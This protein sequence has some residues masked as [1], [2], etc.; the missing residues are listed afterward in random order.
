MII[1]FCTPGYRGLAH[2][3][4]ASAERHGHDVEIIDAPELGDWAANCAQKAGVVRDALIRHEQVLFLDADAEV[5]AP[6]DELL[7]P[8]EG[9]RLH[10]V[11]PEQ[12]KPGWF[13]Q[14]YRYQAVKYGGMWNSGILSVHRSPETLA[15]MD[16]W[17]EMCA[18]RPSEWDQLCLQWAHRESGSTVEVRDIPAQYRAGKAIIGHRSAFHTKWKRAEDVPLRRVVLLGSAEYVSE[19]WAANRS[20]YLDRGFAVAAVNNACAVAGDDLDLWLTP[21]DY[22][23]E[24]RADAAPNNVASYPRATNP[25]GNWIAHPHWISKPTT[26]M[27]SA[28][29]HLLNEAVLDGCRIE[30]HVAGCDMDY[31]ANQTHFY[32]NGTPDPLRFSDGQL[33]DAQA[34]LM[35]MYASHM[36]TIANAGGRETTRL[37]FPR[38][39]PG[40]R[41][42]HSTHSLGEFLGDM[43]PATRRRFER[44]IGLRA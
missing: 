43:T 17:V 21:N 31:G 1:T 32:G 4:R 5:R 20:R 18:R 38:V 6:I 29:L 22:A 16:A 39:E 27:L 11:T 30:V 37:I 35:G 23:G 24:F 12:F 25:E 7:K 8:H 9:I 13:A 40:E 36:S 28:A 26:V 19:W 10:V 41:A 2:K 34:R 33:R 14:R 3:L 42:A 44:S 15:L